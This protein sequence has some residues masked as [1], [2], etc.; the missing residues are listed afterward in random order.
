M[1]GMFPLNNNDP[2]A[3]GKAAY[4]LKAKVSEQLMVKYGRM[5]D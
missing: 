5:S 1:V 3:F 4:I 2:K